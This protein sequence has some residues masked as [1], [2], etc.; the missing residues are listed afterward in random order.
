[1]DNGKIVNSGVGL[2][3]GRLTWGEMEQFTWQEI[4]RMT[5]SSKTPKNEKGNPKCVMCFRDAL[6]YRS[7]AKTIGERIKYEID[8]DI[9]IPIDQSINGYPMPVSM[10][11]PKFVMLSFSCELFIKSMLYT[12]TNKVEG[13]DLDELIAKLDC[14]DMESIKK[15]MDHPES[16]D[17]DLKEFNK[18][19]VEFRYSFEKASCAIDTVFINSLSDVLY[20]VSAE[21]I[22]TYLLGD[23]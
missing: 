19:F 8:N 23:A 12:K 10:E 14:G 5:S 11:L 17:S 3:N 4:G 18:P 6:W 7:A 22:N 9:S 15:N 20:L 13:H 16:F 2:I 1:M 21:R